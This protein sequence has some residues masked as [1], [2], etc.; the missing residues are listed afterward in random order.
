MPRLLAHIAS[1]ALA[2]CLVR[3]AS[4]YPDDG[5]PF[6]EGA[7]P[8]V[9]RIYPCA[10]VEHKEA[11]EDGGVPTATFT[12]SDGKRR[13]A[14]MRL[15][16]ST[17]AAGL[18]MTVTGPGG[19]GLAGPQEISG[20]PG[21]MFA[22]WAD[23][24]GDA[25][26]DFVALVWSGGGGS[27]LG[28]ALSSEHGYRITSVLSASP[29]SGDF[30]DL[31]DGKCRVIQTALVRSREPDESGGK[32]REFRVYNLLEFD[33]DRLRVS[34][35]DK[36][37]PKWVLR[38][39]ADGGAEAV[40]LSPEEKARLW[41]AVPERIFRRPRRASSLKDAAPPPEAGTPVLASAG[42]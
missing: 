4:A 14:T 30:I 10:V 41:E 33:G 36:R 42:D 21:A 26:E 24:N 17:G 2:F 11:A 32:A 5:G 22:F 23:L 13:S 18:C 3:S 25:R 39:G 12:R 20:T 6:E 37:F 38:S 8:R 1:A 40:R 15:S 28:F 9:F 34:K 29:G 27:N 16:T 31:G 35:A 19:E 7:R